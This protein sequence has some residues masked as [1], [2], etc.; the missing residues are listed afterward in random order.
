MRA[1]FAELEERGR[2][3]FAAEGLEGA[4]EKMVDMRYRRQGYE[5]NVPWDEESP[6]RTMEAFHDLHRQRYGFADAQRPV[7]IV[8]LRLR[9]VAAGEAY[10]PERMEPVAGDGGAAFYAERNVYFD[11]RFV[12]TRFYRRDGLCAG[13][14]VRG[15]AMITEYTA[16]TVLPPGAELRVDGLGN[17]VIGFKEARA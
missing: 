15:P 3:E 9:M 10:E 4:A 5:L 8:N 12:P 7:E 11:G 17:L 6:E 13:D 1:A 14:V 2:A 16:A